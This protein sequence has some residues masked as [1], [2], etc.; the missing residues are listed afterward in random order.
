MFFGR[1]LILSFLNM[2]F[3]RESRLLPHHG[4]L[5]YH[6]FAGVLNVN[7]LGRRFARIDADLRFFF[8]Q[9]SSLCELRRDTSV[10]VK[11][12]PYKWIT[13]LAM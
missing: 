3:F 13:C 1:K 5:A 6:R 2:T 7:K 4:D 8:T 12:A 10:F 11:T 9:P